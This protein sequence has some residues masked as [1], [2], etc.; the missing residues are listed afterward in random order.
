MLPDFLK[1]LNYKVRKVRI[2]NEQSADVITVK[3]DSF[4]RF[5]FLASP[6]FPLWF[7]SMSLVVIS[8]SLIL[9]FEDSL[10][11]KLET[12]WLV[13]NSEL[14]KRLAPSL[15]LAVIINLETKAASAF[16]LFNTLSGSSIR[17]LLDK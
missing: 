8:P 15:S 1:H 12:C 4:S 5:F 10:E 3:A 17:N 6:F 13:R 14:V 11:K 9:H 7:S 2:C 16:R